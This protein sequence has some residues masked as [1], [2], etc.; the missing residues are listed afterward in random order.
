MAIPQEE[1]INQVV[2]DFPSVKSPGGDGMTYEFIQD[3]WSFVGGACR[4]MV[5]DF[6]RDAKLTSNMV[7]GIVKMVPKGVEEL[8]IV[9][10]QRNLTMLTTTYKIISKILTERFKPMIPRLVDWQHTGFV[11]G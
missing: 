3:S 6:W 5:Q 9:D 7:N 2:F 1:E 4:D 8:Q 11:K 10:N